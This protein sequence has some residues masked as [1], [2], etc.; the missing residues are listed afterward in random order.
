MRGC[1]GRGWRE[2]EREG[3]L[4]VVVAVVGVL[5]GVLEPVLV[6]VVGHDV[7]RAQRSQLRRSI[8]ARVGCLGVGTG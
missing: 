3:G 7:V 4:F 6:R 1:G 2:R 5:V 8:V